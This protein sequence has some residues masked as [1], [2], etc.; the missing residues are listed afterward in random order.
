MAELLFFKVRRVC[1]ISSALRYQ[2]KTIFTISFSLACLAR[3]F[4]SVSY[5]KIDFRPLRY[6]CASENRLTNGNLSWYYH[7]VKVRHLKWQN[8]F[9][10]KVRRLCTNSLAFRYKKDISTIS[11]GLAWW[12]HS[13][14]PASCKKIDF[15][16]LR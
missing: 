4:F 14:F 12:A 16:P 1:T 6:L 5:K 13:F 15:G 9:F 10:F 11:L 8:Y 2:K 7:R 3:S